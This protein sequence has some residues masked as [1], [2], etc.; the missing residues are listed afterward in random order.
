MIWGE[1]HDGWIVILAGRRKFF[2]RSHGWTREL[3]EDLVRKLR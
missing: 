1:V 3:L 2:E